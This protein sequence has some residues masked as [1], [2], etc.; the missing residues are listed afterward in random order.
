MLHLLDLFVAW[1]APEL[2]RSGH[3]SIEERK[4]IRHAPLTGA[5]PAAPIRRRCWSGRP[6]PPRRPTTPT[7]TTSTGPARALFFAST[8]A[9]HLLLHVFCGPYRAPRPA[10]VVMA[11]PKTTWADPDSPWATY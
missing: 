3:D 11:A 5:V 10:S 2:A 9:A 7:I 8:A 1:V 6:R 4:G